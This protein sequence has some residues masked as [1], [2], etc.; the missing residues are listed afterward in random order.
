MAKATE[1]SVEEKLRQLYALQKADTKIDEIE[2]LKGE[3]PI[4]V[5]DLEDEIT[6]L[7]TRLKNLN[8]TAKDIEK[9]G[10]KFLTRI[11]EGEA[12]IKKYTKQLDDV[13]NNREFDALS[14]ELEMQKLEIQLAEKKARENAEKVNA[15]NAVIK[16]V[17]DKYKAKKANLDLKK[18]ELKSIVAKTE[19]DEKA[20]RKIAA[21]A[22][23]V[24]DPRLLNAYHRIRNNYRNGLALVAIERDSCGGCFNQ[25][26]PQIQ[27]EVSQRKKIIACE[28]CGRILVDNEIAGVTVE[29]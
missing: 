19:K 22:E 23:A 7:E 18:D 12:L 10:Q 28:H 25:I 2:I 26:P 14:K 5:S 24:I 16:E 15:K 3:L 21:T 4:E 9:E 8:E 27:L 11:S 13:K 29:A 17:K 6:G 1:I 20:L